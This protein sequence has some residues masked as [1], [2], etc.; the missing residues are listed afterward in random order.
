[1]SMF[2]QVLMHNS[3]SI[4]EKSDFWHF[5]ISS[6]REC[7]TKKR[8]LD[9]RSQRHNS[10]IILRK[11]F[12][13]K[14]WFLNDKKNILPCVAASQQGIII[15]IDLNLFAS[16]PQRQKCLS[17]F[18]DVKSDK[19]DLFVQTAVPCLEYRLHMGIKIGFGP[20]LPSVWMEPKYFSATDVVT[21]SYKTTC[22]VKVSRSLPRMTAE[23][24]MLLNHWNKQFE[25]NVLPSGFMFGKL[26]HKNQSCLVKSLWAIYYWSFFSSFLK[27]QRPVC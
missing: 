15:T 12:G 7:G 5:S 1:M 10:Q 27:Q 16:P 3:K 8:I 21:V 9:N 19:C 6:Q 4:F 17:H 2:S 18:N 24:L 25:N 22:S 13:E 20:H 26:F 23:L 14:N 11:S